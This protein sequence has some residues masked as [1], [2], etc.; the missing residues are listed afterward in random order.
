MSIDEPRRVAIVGAYGRIGAATAARLAADGHEVVGFVRDGSAPITEPPPVEVRPT[1]FGDPGAVGAALAGFDLVVYAVG[2][3]H[4]AV[5]V[6]S[7]LAVFEANALLAQR[8]ALAAAMGGATR[9]VYLSS[10]AAM[11]ATEQSTVAPGAYVRSKALAE[12]TLPEC[13][14]GA[15]T[16]IR[17]GWV[18]DPADETA[19]RNLWPSTGV[20]L[21]VGGLPVPMVA[22]ADVAAAIAALAVADPADTAE[23]PTVVDLVGGCPTQ[24]ELY[25]VVRHLSA[26]PMRVVDARTIERVARLA[27]LRRDAVEPPTWLTQS[28]PPCT[29]DWSVYGVRLRSWQDC[30][31][32]LRGTPAESRS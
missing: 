21:I 32:M 19:R 18:I 23:L 31:A 28:A 29:V 16:I 15:L 4:G 12:R 27:E 10:T 13:F 1:D 2:A 7:P 14:P 25:E 9:F 20:Q 8:V 11:G 5:E 6:I 24:R 3:H 22:L 30:V 26:E 17:L